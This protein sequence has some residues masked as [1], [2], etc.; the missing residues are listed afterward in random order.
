MSKPYMKMYW[1]DY[2]SDTRH[3]NAQQHGAYICLI[4]HYFQNDGLPAD[5]AQLARIACMSRQQWAANR[6]I[7]SSF[8]EPGWL[9]LRI[10]KEILDMKS[11]T[12]TAREKR[13]NKRKKPN[14]AV[15]KI[16]HDIEEKSAE[17]NDHNSLILNNRDITAVNLEINSRLTISDINISPKGPLLTEPTPVTWG[18]N[19]SSERSKLELECRTLVGEEPIQLQA[20]FHILEDLKLHGTEVNGIL[21]SVTDED[22]LTAV[23]SA[24]ANPRFRLKYWS[25]LVGWVKKSAQKR[26]GS[27]IKSAYSPK[28]NFRIEG[29]LGIKDPPHE[30]SNSIWVESDDPRW[31]G[32]AMRW[33]SENSKSMGPPKNH[34]R[35]SRDGGWMFPK[36]WLNSNHQL[37]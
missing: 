35:G 8:F 5:E 27:K 7:I 29:I 16:S 25:Q 6:D 12:Q 14:H 2:F 13:L 15:L 24:M 11:R 10:E 34:R 19:S 22:I 31:E 18:L 33:R 4:G 23:K 28:N 26:L 9:H 37:D 17:L 21:V 30:P 3:L 32:L 1:G 20:D 36:E